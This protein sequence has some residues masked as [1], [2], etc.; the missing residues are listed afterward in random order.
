M[1]DVSEGR[2]HELVFSGDPSLGL[3]VPRNQKETAIWR[4][5]PNLLTNLNGPH[6]K[7]NDEGKGW[8]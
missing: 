3:G 6:E 7:R 5:P 1:K 2:I 8:S 4:A